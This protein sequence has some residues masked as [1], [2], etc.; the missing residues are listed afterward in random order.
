MFTGLIEV[1]EFIACIPLPSHKTKK[2]KQDLTVKFYGYQL[3]TRK[4]QI[5]F[6]GPQ[7]DHNS[8]PETGGTSEIPNQSQSR[9][10][11]DDGKG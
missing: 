10:H 3:E 7:Y 8:S 2:G 6:I 1:S 4:S 9:S 5:A 11:I